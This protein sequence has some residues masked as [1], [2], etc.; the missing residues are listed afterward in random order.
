MKIITSAPIIAPEGISGADGEDFLPFDGMSIEEMTGFID[1]ETGNI[2]YS[3]D[4]ETF[5]YA[6]GVK[7]K[8]SGFLNVLKKVGKGIG[9]GAKA[10]GKTIKKG[11]QAIGRTIRNIRIKKQ[12]RKKTKEANIKEVKTKTAPK[13]APLS[14]VKPADASAKAGATSTTPQYLSVLPTAKPD[15]PPENKVVANGKE[16]DATSIPKDAKIVV[17]TDDQGNQTIGAEIP[18][19]DVVAIRSSDGNYDYFPKNAV[20]DA[21]VVEDKKSGGFNKV[22]IYG[23]I[24]VAVGLIIFLIVRQRNK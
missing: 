13:S 4:N 21:E 16:Y 19:N 1:D 15:T 2:Y 10:V 7:A 17:G 8:G 5:Y 6:N 18:P 12:E 23:G 22:L 11:V 20:T 14:V 3:A 24:A 9:K